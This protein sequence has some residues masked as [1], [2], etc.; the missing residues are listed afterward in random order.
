MIPFSIVME[1]EGVDGAFLLENPWHNEA[2]NDVPFMIG[3]NSADGGVKATS[4]RN[5]DIFSIS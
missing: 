3:C 2:I 1:P 5:C 4:E